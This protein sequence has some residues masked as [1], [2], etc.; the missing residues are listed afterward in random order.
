MPI[1]RVSQKL[2]HNVVPEGEAIVLNDEMT[3]D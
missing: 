3:N 1:A 2:P